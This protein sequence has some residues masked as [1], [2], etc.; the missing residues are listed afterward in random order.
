MVGIFP[1]D[2]VRSLAFYGRLGIDL[3]QDSYRQHFF[4]PE[5]A[6]A[7]GFFLNSTQP[8]VAGSGAVAI[9]FRLF[10]RE[11][12]DQKRSQLLGAGGVEGRPPFTTPSGD[13]VAMLKDPDGLL[14]ALSCAVSVG[15][16]SENI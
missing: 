1:R 7:V 16:P 8:A 10:D 4:T 5:T 13:Y 15:Y 6:G 14:I 2:V 12:V 9:E 11:A 3:R